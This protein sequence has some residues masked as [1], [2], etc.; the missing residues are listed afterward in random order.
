MLTDLRGDEDLGQVC[1]S[2]DPESLERLAETRAE[3]DALRFLAVEEVVGERRSTQDDG[4][5]DGHE[6][7]NHGDEHLSPA[8]H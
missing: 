8:S 1:A 6:K 3:P 7:Q 2:Q 5:A 4:E